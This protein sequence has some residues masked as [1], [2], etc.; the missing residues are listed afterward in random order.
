MQMAAKVGRRSGVGGPNKADDDEPY[1][2]Y[3]KAEEPSSST[4]DYPANTSSQAHKSIFDDDQSGYKPS[5]G[6]SRPNGGSIFGANNASTDAGGSGYQPSSA[7]GGG[8]NFASVVRRRKNFLL[9]GPVSNQSPL[10]TPLSFGQVLCVFL[11][12]VCDSACACGVRVAWFYAC[13][14]DAITCVLINCEIWY[15]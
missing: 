8:G 7:A 6:A 2:P 4:R 5:V 12:C 11:C 15:L 13:I 3:G 10:D 1:R 14:C 9:S